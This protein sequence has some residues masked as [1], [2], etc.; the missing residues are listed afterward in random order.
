[1]KRT[2]STRELIIHAARAGVS[3]ET[4]ARLVELHIEEHTR[5]RPGPVRAVWD[6][7]VDVFR[8]FVE[9]LTYPARVLRR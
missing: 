4:L 6:G 3:D 2:P 5:T 9:V 8:A 1:M 7:L